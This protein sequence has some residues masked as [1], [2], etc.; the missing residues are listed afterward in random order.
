[1]ELL[2]NVDHNLYTVDYGRNMHEVI[3]SFHDNLMLQGFMHEV[4]I[5]FYDNLMR[6][7]FFA[8]ALVC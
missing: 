2:F 8:K 6:H 7:Q 5:S 4:I 3:T 1:M